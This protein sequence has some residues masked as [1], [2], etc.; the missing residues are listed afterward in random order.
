MR[1]WIATLLITITLILPTAAI[2]DG[3]GDVLELP[4]MHDFNPTGWNWDFAPNDWTR[5]DT[6]RQG[7]VITLSVIDWGQTHEIARRPDH[8]EA[9]PILGP[10]PSPGE[11]N[12]Y[13]IASIALHTAAVVILPHR[14]RKWVQIVSIYNEGSVVLHN[15]N[16]GIRLRLHF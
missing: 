12:R 1:H 6:I 7:A 14:I 2:A 5:G 13:F 15:Y 4:T 16:A 8:F 9:N 11:I 10:D 3:V